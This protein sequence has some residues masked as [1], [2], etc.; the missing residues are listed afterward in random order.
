MSKTAGS[1]ES[2]KQPIIPKI[3]VS[4]RGAAR[5]KDGRVWVYRS[6]VAA[7]EGIP[8]GSIVNVVD[9]RGQSLGTALYSSS[10]RIAIRMISNEAVADFPALLRQRIVEA[11]AYRERVVRD[12]D[13]YRII[14]S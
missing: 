12:S 9:H 11:I 14:F 6:D 13:A 10:S 3:K 5:L 4:P 8:A 7:A 2:P 1:P